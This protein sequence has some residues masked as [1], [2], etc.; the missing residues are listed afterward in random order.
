MIA[1][2]TPLTQMGGDSILQ[3][4][5]V[6]ERKT[7]ARVQHTACVPERKTQHATLGRL[8]KS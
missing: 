7:Q 5:C 8:L 4:V 6:T 2:N 3:R 1:A